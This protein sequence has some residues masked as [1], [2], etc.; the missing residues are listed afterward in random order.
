MNLQLLVG[1]DK[2]SPVLEQARGPNAVSS[3]IISDNLALVTWGRF[4][5]AGRREV[6]IRG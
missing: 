4:S 2:S 3:Q 5:S 6:S 1:C